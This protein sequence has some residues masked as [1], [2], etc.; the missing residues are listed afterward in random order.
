VETELVSYQRARAVVLEDRLQVRANN[1]DVLRLVAATL[2]LLSHCFALT[3][4]PEPFAALTGWTMGKLGVVMFFVMSGF[5]IAKSWSDRPR[6]RPFAAKRTLRLIPGLVVAVLFTA[7]VIGPLFTTLGVG[8]YLA[9]PATWAYVVRNSVLYTIGGRLPGV[10]EGNVYPDAVNGSLWTLPVEAAAYGMVAVLGIVGLLR[11]S[12]AVL[13]VCALALLCT[14]PLVPFATTTSEGVGGGNLVIVAALIAAF[15][16]GS[17]LYSAR[18]RLRMAWVPC[19]ALLVLWAATWGSA[20]TTAF[21]VVAVGA[22]VVVA[23]FRTPDGLRRITAH[24]DVSYG[25]YLYAFPVQQSIAALAAPGLQPLAMF[26]LALPVTYGLALASWR[27]VE[28][29]ALALKRRVS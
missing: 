15:L 25:L 3:G 26:A 2:V 27:V 10:F 17:L 5:L 21:G 13:A 1:F 29:P 6:L 12:P 19:A 18:A 8:D 16:F 7:L 9:D 20:W 24:G 22:C 14:T 23:A 11:R 28:R 4:R